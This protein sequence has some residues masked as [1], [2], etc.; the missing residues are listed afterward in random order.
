MQ[1]KREQIK[2]LVENNKEIF[3]GAFLM[4]VPCDEDINAAKQALGFKIPESYLWF[5]KH[6]GYGGFFFSFL[7]YGL[8]G[9]V[10]F[11]QETLELRKRGLPENLMVIE[12]NDEYVIC[13]DVQSGNVVSWSYHDSSGII[14]MNC[15]FE[16]YFLERLNNAIDNY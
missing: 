15:C 13:I 10:I 12:N 1:T 11:V 2:I 9:E 6:Y 7:G 8:T 16:D 4:N 5:L 14:I 3:E